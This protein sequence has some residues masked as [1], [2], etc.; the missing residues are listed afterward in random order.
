[1][2]DDVQRRL[3]ALL[4][5]MQKGGDASCPDPARAVLHDLLSDARRTAQRGSRK[6]RKPAAPGCVASPAPPTVPIS[7]RLSLAGAPPCDACNVFSVASRTLVLRGGRFQRARVVRSKG[8]LQQPRKFP[9]LGLR[10][11]SG[12]DEPVEAFPIGVRRQDIEQLLRHHVRLG[13]LA[14]ASGADPGQLWPGIGR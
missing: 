12:V 14:G 10:Q 6:D 3:R 9:C 1:M 11:L 4:D 5:V 2:A 13:S 8:R 7:S